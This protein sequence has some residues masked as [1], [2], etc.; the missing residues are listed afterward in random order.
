MTVSREIQLFTIS[1]PA[2]ATTDAI[3]AIGELPWRTAGGWHD[4]NLGITIGQITNTIGTVLGFINVLGRICPF[5][6]TR[7]CR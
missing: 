6:T 5:G 2:D 3:I 7:R 4:I 1:T